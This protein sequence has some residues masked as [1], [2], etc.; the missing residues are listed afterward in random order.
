MNPSPVTRLITFSGIDGAGKST[1]IAA[2]NDALAARG[3]KVSRI[4]F[5][6]NAAIFPNFRA[7]VSLRML[8]GKEEREELPSLRND[9]NVRAWYLTL[10]RSAFYLLDAVHLRQVVGRLQRSGADFIILDRCS[11]DQLVHIRPH[12]SLARAYIRTVLTA[13]PEPTVA[14]VLDASPEDAFRRKPEYPL[15]F[16]H[17]YRQAYLDLRQFVPQLKVIAPGSVEDV[18]K[19]IVECVLD[20]ASSQRDSPACAH[21]ESEVL[22][23]NSP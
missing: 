12:H 13:T 11:Y 9:K 6:E 17:E 2:L 16:M 15:G 1:Q 7:S 3:L 10:I 22:L 5:W 20:H 8:R 21:E 14:F 4:S 19:Q 18:H 23:S